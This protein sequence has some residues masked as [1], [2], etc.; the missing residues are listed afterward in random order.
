MR[1]RSARGAAIAAALAAVLLASGCATAPDAAGTPLAPAGD[2]ARGREVFVARDAGH[3]VLCHRAP[4]LSPAGDVGPS[5]AGI[6]A[7]LSVPQLRYRVID[8]TRLKPDAAMPAFF[9]TAGLVRVAPRYA[10]RPVLT[11]R[12]VEDVVAYLASL[13]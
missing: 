4:G 10:H 6:G 3:C 1:R 11:A 9:R 13:K 12:Q 2:A 5:L 7:R 8:I